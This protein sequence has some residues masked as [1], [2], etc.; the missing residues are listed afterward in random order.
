MK[1]STT[2]TTSSTTSTFWLKPGDLVTQCQS[3]YLVIAVDKSLYLLKYF[4]IFVIGPDG[5]LS[6]VYVDHFE[7]WSS[8]KKVRVP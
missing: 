1:I 5:S 6:D 7:E 3:I 8:I 2:I 4:R